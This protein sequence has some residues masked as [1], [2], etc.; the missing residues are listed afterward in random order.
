MV[1]SRATKHSTKNICAAV[2]I[3]ST[4]SLCTAVSASEVTFSN[5]VLT[6]IGDDTP[7]VITVLVV[8]G[9]V[10]VKINDTEF[11][12]LAPVASVTTLII[13]G[14]G[15]DDV[16]DCSALPDSVAKTVRGGGGNDTIIG[17]TD[18]DLD[19]DPDGDDNAAPGPQPVA[20][21]CGVGMCGAGAADFFLLTAFGLT[22]MSLRRR[23]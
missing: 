15:G 13:E 2:L 19:D 22:F 7:D 11:N 23:F 10:N 4:L 16:I 14:R 12:N 21:G 20:P 1:N 8:N 17:A 5:G 6:I 9:I 18:A 3:A